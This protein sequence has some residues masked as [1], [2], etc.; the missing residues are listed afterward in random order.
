MREVMR[1]APGDVVPFNIVC[2]AM[3]PDYLST[4]VSIALEHSGSIAA[5][6][7]QALRRTIRSSVRIPGFDRDPS[8]APLQILKPNV[9]H[10]VRL[11]GD[12]MREVLRAWK[13]RKQDLESEMRAVLESKSVRIVDDLRTQTGF[14]IPE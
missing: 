4:V 10:M 5:P 9:A 1:P 7:L 3:R 12:L 14:Q 2:Q 8:K 13:A 6:G 11:N